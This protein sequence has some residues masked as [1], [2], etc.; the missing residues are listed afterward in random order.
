MRAR[1]LL[2]GG[3]AAVQA[4]AR[5][6]G[7]GNV[8][9]DSG[10]EDSTLHGCGSRKM[11]GEFTTRFSLFQ[12]GLGC[13]LGVRFRIWTHGHMLLCVLCLCFV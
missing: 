13:S 4:L 8:T 6:F 12:W 1:G 5:R 10:S 11:V 7:F 3:T 9:T 2:C